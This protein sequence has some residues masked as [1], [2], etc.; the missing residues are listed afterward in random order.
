MV[1]DDD[2]HPLVVVGL[3]AQLSQ[4]Q[5]CRPGL[6]TLQQGLRRKAAHSQNH[7]GLD[8]GD[9]TLQKRLAGQ[10]LL[11]L[12]DAHHSRPA[13]HHIGQV[14]LLGRLS[15]LA[16]AAPELERAQHVVH[17]LPGW[18]GKGAAGPL[19]LF[20]RRLAQHQPVRRLHRAR[21]AED[22]CPAAAA[23]LAGLA[24][25]HGLQQGRRVQPGGQGAVA[26]DPGRIGA[27]ISI[28]LTLIP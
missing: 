20:V 13:L 19:L 9:F 6:T 23:Q 2:R 26:A 15:R 28:K 3:A 17:Q 8:Q 5:R 18:P 12:R 25:G 1:G 4:R 7:L 14:C 21:L 24:A 16:G 22:R 10:Q 27:R 11:R